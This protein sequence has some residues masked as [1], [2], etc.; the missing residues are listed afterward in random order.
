MRGVRHVTGMFGLGDNIYQRAVVRDMGPV[1]LVTPWPQLYK[2]L[3]LVE[4]LPATTVLRT[5]NKNVRRGWPWGAPLHRYAAGKVR[6]GYD[7]ADGTMLERFIHYAKLPPGRPVRF[8]L[9]SFGSITTMLDRPYVV[10]RPATIRTEWPASSRNP[11]PHYIA[12]A[13]QAAQVAGYAV[14][15]VADIEEGVEDLVGMPPPAD[16]AA[17]HGE[18]DVDSLM[19]LVQHAA[20]VI[21][22]VGW[23]LPA[24]LA[25]R[26]PMLCIWGGWGT[27]NGPARVLDE[28]IDSSALV[29]AIPDAF[30]M[31]NDRDHHCDKAISN[32]R[33]HVDEFLELATGPNARL[34]A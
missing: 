1:H 11:D 3:P 23:L 5:Q 13:A 14:V 16:I 2:D 34:A 18:F 10:V 21:G 19:G 9:P 4:C 15:C 24:A 6:V 29:Q 33:R 7:G 25:Y 30:C 20:G 17:L 12:Q 32:F 27:M 28:R 31:C 26:T 8:D 22:G